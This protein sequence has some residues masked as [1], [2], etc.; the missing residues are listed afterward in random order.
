MLIIMQLI[1]SSK[2]IA[3]NGIEFMCRLLRICS[4]S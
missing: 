1:K 2:A 3:R 4:F